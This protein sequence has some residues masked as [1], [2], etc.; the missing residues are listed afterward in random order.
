MAG[1]EEARKKV[2]AEIVNGVLRGGCESENAAM[3]RESGM[4]PGRERGESGEEGG[5]KRREKR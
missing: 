4:K 5:W 3:G 2:V 1:L